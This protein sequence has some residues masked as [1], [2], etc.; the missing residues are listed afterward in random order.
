MIRHM[1]T[2]RTMTMS[3]KRHEPD[4]RA[5]W[6]LRHPGKFGTIVIRAKRDG[7]R[8]YHQKGG[9]QSTV[10]A[11]GVSLDIYVHALHGLA[12]QRGKKVLMIG[13]AGGTLATMLARGGRDVTVVD[14]DR[15]AFKLA[16]TYFYMPPEVSCRTGD[17]LRF[18]EKVAARFDVV[19]VDAFIGEAIPAHFTGEAFF[20]AARRCVKRTG[21][22]LVNVC[23][24]GRKDRLADEIAAGFEARGWGVKLLDEPGG[25]RN[26]VVAAGNVAGLRKPR[27]SM[28]PEV[29]AKKLKKG[30]NAMSFRAALR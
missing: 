23:L 30:V 8:G 21:V 17:G 28:A 18:M 10:D 7:T 15:Q 13:C 3:D 11:D 6:T 27:V 24:H 25:A 4:S 26:A 16:K 5:G 9:N 20:T 1:Q 22:I 2:Q 14:I 19:V 12:L 29:G